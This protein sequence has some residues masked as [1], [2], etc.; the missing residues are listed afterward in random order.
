MLGERLQGLLL[1]LAGCASLALV[2]LVQQHGW[3]ELRPPTPP[4][5]RPEWVP[6]VTPVSCILPMAALGAVG[7][8]W[9]GLK[10]LFSID[11][12]RPPRH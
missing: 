2:Y 8:C 4:G 12:G 5:I 3:L 1:I 11:D 7:L 10:K 6:V 9:V